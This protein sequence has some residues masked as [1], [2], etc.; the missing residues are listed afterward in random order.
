[1]NTP[2]LIPD[3]ET[4]CRILALLQC[5][6]AMLA[7]TDRLAAIIAELIGEDPSGDTITEAVYNAQDPATAVMFLR[8][9]LPTAGRAH[10]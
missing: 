3:R 7:E 9:D 4:E 2:N 6:H 5:T 10:A 8:G 1:M